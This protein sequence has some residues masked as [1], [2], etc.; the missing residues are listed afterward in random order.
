MSYKYKL[1]PE[2]VYNQILNN[3]SSGNVLKSN[4]PPEAKILLYQ[5]QARN[6]IQEKLNKEN[7]PVVVRDPSLQSKLDQVL[8]F[9][10]PPID[11]NPL[12]EQE[13]AVLPGNIVNETQTEA[14]ENKR[15]QKRVQQQQIRR[16]NKKL[17]LERTLPVN[18]ER[19]IQ[20]DLKNKIKIIRRK[21]I[22]HYRFTPDYKPI[23]P[24]YKKT[25]SKRKNE[26]DGWE[27]YI[28]SGKA[29]KVTITSPPPLNISKLMTKRQ[30]ND[31]KVVFKRLEKDEHDA[32][33]PKRSQRLLNKKIKGWKSY[34]F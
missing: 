14:T 13:E 19:E 5:E 21:D 6:L 18:F 27:D 8:Q 12:E 1:V 2:G 22:N 25:A 16:P 20:K 28:D 26:A 15:G 4:L 3:E 24:Q 23:R 9:L 17:I 30:I 11:M 31:K 34:P 32:Q 7:R 10:T 33:I 29:P